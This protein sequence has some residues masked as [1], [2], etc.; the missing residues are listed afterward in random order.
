[1]RS[2]A[3]NGTD[4]RAE[5]GARD[6]F[7]LVEVLATMTISAFLLAA[8]FSIASFVI[9][10]SGRVES[11][12]QTIENRSRIFAS[13][14]REIEQIAPLRWPGKGSGFV[15]LGTQG[16]LA[17]ASRKTSTDNGDSVQAVFLDVAR[18]GLTRRLA[19][20]SPVAT[21]FREL[22]IGPAEPVFGGRYSVAF[23]YYGRV[24]G[25]REALQDTWQDPSQLPAAIR[26]TL[27]DAHGS[28]ETMRIQLRADA[29]TGCAQSGDATCSLRPASSAS[30]E[31]A[32]QEN[33]EGAGGG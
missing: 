19:M 4:Q 31:S 33:D 26:V 11:R 22:R 25:N 7:L 10:A 15:F 2:V 1:M 28:E 29:E 32:P 17:F 27:R 24:E 6:G 12:T 14:S 9:R 8:L 13:L 16:T 5:R 3:G 30:E 20:V 23:A 21:S 18:S